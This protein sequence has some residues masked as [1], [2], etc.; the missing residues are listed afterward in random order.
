MK[1][2]EETSKMGREPQKQFLKYFNNLLEQSIRLK[3]LGNELNLDPTLKDF[4]LRVN[5]IAGIGQL[6]AIIEEL[7]KAVYHI[8]R[9][10]NPKM[11]FMALGIK[12]Y[13]IIQNKTLILTEA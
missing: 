6:E 2:V 11:L 7:D 9:N 13:H 8:E 1:W 5:K 10:A 3:I 4:A 12:F